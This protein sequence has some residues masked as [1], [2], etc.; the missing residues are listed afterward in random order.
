MYACTHWIS[1]D[2][3]VSFFLDD[4]LCFFLIFGMFFLAVVLPC[5]HVCMC[6]Y[7]CAHNPSS[8]GWMSP[9][10]HLFEVDTTGVVPPRRDSKLS[11]RIICCYKMPPNFRRGGAGGRSIVVGATHPATIA[12]AAAKNKDAGGGSALDVAPPQAPTRQTP[13]RV[14]NT[15]IARMRVDA[16]AMM[17]AATALVA[18]DWAEPTPGVSVVIDGVGRQSGSPPSSPPSAGGAG[19]LGSNAPPI[20]TTLPPL[21]NAW[22]C[23]G[24]RALH[25]VG[26]GGALRGECIMCGHSHPVRNDGML[27]PEQLAQL[28]ATPGLSYDVAFAAVA[29]NPHRTDC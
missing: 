10:S 23:G 25:F 1:W 6:A 3:P 24:C 27:D 15:A 14:S 7:A 20:E 8:C 29:P 28:R 21:W 26:D 22:W 16:I 2:V 13:P 4:A 18:P 5:L 19:P 17:H 12:T 11:R 9:T